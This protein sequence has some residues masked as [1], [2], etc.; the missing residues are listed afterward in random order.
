MPSLEDGDVPHVVN[1]GHQPEKEKEKEKDES[2][3]QAS[4]KRRRR[5]GEGS[6][7]LQRLKGISMIGTSLL[8]LRGVVPV[9]LEE[10]TSTRY[11]SFFSIWISININLLPITFGMLGP[12]LGL[13]LVASSLVIVLF[14][15]LTAAMPAYLGTL[16]PRT[17]MRQMVQA[18]FSFGKAGVVVPVLLN[19]ATLT[20]YC[21]VS[22]VIGAQCLVAVSGGSGGNDD[23]KGDGAALTP[24]LGIAIIGI[25]CLL[26][27]FCGYRVLH[28]YERWAWIP[29]LLAVVIT[30]GC[31]G[32]G[33]ASQSQESSST[34]TVAGV[35]SFG[36]VIASYMIP[37]AAM[38]SDFTTYLS[39]SFPSWKLFLYGF[40]GLTLPSIPLMVLG[41]AI[42]GALPNHPSWEKGYETNFLGGTL[43]SILLKPLGAGFGRLILVILSLT[44][45]GNNAATLYS[46]TLNCQLLSPRLLARVPRSVFSVL[47][48]AVVIP[49]GIRAAEDF[50]QNLQNFI[51][52]I[53][54]W[55]AAFVAVV[56]VEHVCFRSRRRRRRRDG[57]P[58]EE[59][60]GVVVRDGIGAEVEVEEEAYDLD[61]WDN[62]SKLPWGVA[63][64]GAAVSSF[65][66][67]IPSMAQVWF[68]GPI[69][70]TTGDVGFELA[71]VVTAILYIPFRALEKR[72]CGR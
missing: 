24:A 9:P 66:L 14:C 25:A 56:V 37:Y 20:G 60:A 1:V 70:R 21:V 42:G 5:R 59:A 45:I 49:V 67:V 18:R 34:N 7:T 16:G 52:L 17:G 47:V 27:S 38:A 13:S 4:E 10:R 68:T 12:F 58:E 39:P 19:L 36:M 31:A 28:T 15:A 48:T 22:S 26:I 53:A 46:I 69:A 6:R 8:E 50:Y 71:F 43:A 32:K 23:G 11:S 41:A 29:G 2:H 44:L 62:A 54:Y 65:G 72:L 57:N 35:F 40:A 33:L 30:A 51:A 61:A 64:L 55:S 63:A 3:V